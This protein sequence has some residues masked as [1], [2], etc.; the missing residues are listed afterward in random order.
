MIFFTSDTHFWHKNIIEHCD[1]PWDTVEEMNEGLIERWNE[2]VG[3]HDT[4]YH[5]GDFSFGNLDKTTEVF[6]RLNGNKLL[7]KGN[8]DGKAVCQQGWGWVKD[9]YKIKPKTIFEDFDGNPREVGRQIALCHF[10]HESWEN[11]H[12]GA[13]HL[14]GHCHGT[15]PDRGGL[16]VDMGV[17]NLQFW[18]AYRPV[19]FTELEEL[20]SG[21]SFKKVDHHGK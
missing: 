19:A 13:W 17:D 11:M 3:P 1:R 9:Y 5:L 7:V 4:V 21:R 20:M 18:Y 16:R 12:H 15:L 6:T 8:H 2:V 10:P 14:H